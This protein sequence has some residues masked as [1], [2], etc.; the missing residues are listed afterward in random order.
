MTK[1]TLNELSG[2]IIG[3][4]INVHKELGP[5]LLE[6]AYRNFLSRELSLQGIHSLCEKELPYNYKGLIMDNV[7]KMDMVVDDRIIVEI[8]AVNTL[9]PVHEAQ[10]LTYLKLSGLT[11]GLLINFN[12]ILLRDGIKR[13]V[14]NFQEN[15]DCE[16]CLQD[17]SS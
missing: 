12:V 5:G 7:Y 8:K 16:K 11:L 2:R 9:T 6:S 1:T 13:I 3:A 10:L 17:H 4:A 15:H 14:L